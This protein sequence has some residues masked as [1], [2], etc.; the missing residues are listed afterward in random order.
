MKAL[1][2]LSP[3]KQAVADASQ[4]DIIG[5]VNG[6][7]AVDDSLE[8]VTLTSYQCNELHYDVSS[9]HGGLVVFSE[10]YYPG[11]TATLDGKPLQLARVD[12]TLRGAVVPAGQHKIAMEFRPKSVKT[13]EAIAYSAIAVLVI[14]FLTSLGI[15]LRRQTK[16][17][18]KAKA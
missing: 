7:N 9:P 12:Y 13:T 6:S 11:W 15:T 14:A 2:A 1:L 3:K 10:I 5:T 17:E 8:Q 16:G 4:R 18:H